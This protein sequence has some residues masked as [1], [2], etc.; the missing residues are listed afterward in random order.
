MTSLSSFLP[1]FG[2]FPTSMGLN[3]LVPSSFHVRAEQLDHGWVSRFSNTQLEPGKLAIVF[4]LW[5]RATGG[6]LVLD[7]RTAS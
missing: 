5:E 7:Q 1:S 6:F 3:R 4:K 2:E